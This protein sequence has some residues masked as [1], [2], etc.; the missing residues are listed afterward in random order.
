MATFVSERNEVSFK[1]VYCGAPRSGKTTNLL[2]IHKRLDPH[3]RGDLIS[4]A[5]EEDRTLFFDFLPVHAAEVGDF[6]AKFQLFTVPGQR[7]YARNR[8]IV[9]QESDGIVFVADSSPDRVEA[10]LEALQSVR[11]SLERNDLD[12]DEIPFVFQFNKR[13]LPQAM[14]PQEMDHYLHV[15]TASF[16][17]CALSGYQVFSTLDYL[18]QI[19]V[20]N[21]HCSAVKRLGQVDEENVASSSKIALSS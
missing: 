19:L 21:F 9:L 2:Y 14:P 16:L 17:S 7:A 15:T 12:P 4:L 10:N 18:T 20:K 11:Q 13:D 6:R 3:F 1:I 8:E 5:T